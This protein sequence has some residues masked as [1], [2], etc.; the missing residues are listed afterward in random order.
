MGAFTLWTVQHG[1]SYGS[2]REA[3]KRRGVFAANAAHVAAT[4][5]AATGPSSLRLALNEFADLTW[6]EFSAKKLGFGPAPASAK[7]A[8]GEDAPA[9]LR[10]FTYADDD[11]A[12]LPAA[13]D[14]REHGAVTPVKN[15]AMCGSCWAFSA[16]GAVEGANAIA[17]GKLVS[18]SEQQLV[19]CDSE[20]DMG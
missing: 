20:K 18:L 17:T 1:K 12:A 16:I 13:V 15:Q 2:A 10:P 14:W 7:A 9:G 3:D 11:V 5:A 8:N 6:E 4:N 19:D